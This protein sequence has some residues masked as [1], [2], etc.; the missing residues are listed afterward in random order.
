MT[1]NSK[2]LD[3]IYSVIENRKGNNPASSYTAHLLS[4]GMPEIARKLGEEAIETITAAL[5]AEN[6][7][8]VAESADLLF[9]LLVLW[10][11]KG[12]TPE[13][14]WAELVRREGT[15]GIE[16]KAARPANRSV[17][18]RLDHDKL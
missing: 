13:E 1:E 17:K 9:H 4:Q 12:I 11:E 2:I 8:I 16:E 6:K 10:S 5:T 3:R 15:S 18:G 14:V 7:N